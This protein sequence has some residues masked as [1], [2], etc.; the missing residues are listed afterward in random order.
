MRTNKEIIER[1]QKNFAL[2]KM[3]KVVI[4]KLLKRDTP[5]LPNHIYSENINSDRYSYP[6]TALFG[7]CPCCGSLVND[8]MS[9]CP[10]CGQAV[11]FKGY[12][13]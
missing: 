9:F 3:D 1:V 11:T 5:T 6:I 10:D 12:S 4:V 2:S 8:G 13:A 7:N